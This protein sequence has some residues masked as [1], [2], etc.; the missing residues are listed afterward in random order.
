MASHMVDIPSMGLRI[1]NT[2]TQKKEDF[3]PVT[4][5][6]AS[7]YV[8]GVTVYDHCHI[9]HARSAIVFDTISRYLG[10][11]GYKLT[12]VKNFTDI[13]DKII[14]KARAEGISWKEVSEKYIA[15]FYEDMNALNILRPT[16]EPRATDH[17]DEMIG[18]VEALL[19]K[20]HA[21]KSEGD[22]YFSVESYK[23]YG[24]LSKR[25]LEE[26][27]A[28]ARVDINE[29]KQNPLDFAL[30]KASKPD[31]PSWETPFG[32][33][34]PGWHIEC[35]A[36][37]SKYLG[38]P[39]DIH[40]GGKDLV[41]PHH[42]NERA[43][44]EAATGVTF[45]NYW[46]HNGFVNVERE[47]MSKSIG[48]ILLIKDFLKQ[49]HPEV[50]RIFFLG[51]HY[52]NPVDYSERSIED[53]DS[54]LHRLYYTRERVSGI[55]ASQKT[56]HHQAHPDAQL[57]ETKFYEAMDDDFNTALALSYIFELSKILN[58]IADDRDES[59]LPYLGSTYQLLMNLTE[60]LGI[61]RDGADSFTEQDRVH[62]LVR[63][64]LEPADVEKAI[65]ERAE[66]RK[67]KDFK[68]AD[69]IR[70]MLSGKGILLLDTAKGT[71][72]RVKNTL[73][74]KGES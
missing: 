28:G 57:L 39:F 32:P 25:P 66:A 59:A 47:K 22:V 68:R 30:W 52:R 34:R 40:G 42:E 60:T 62:H 72:W 41:F 48:N 15:S 10:T 49:Y 26:M 27:E 45:V 14:N 70:D 46:V 55:L 8:C 71:E 54:A 64:G 67:G 29:K 24:Q 3:V 5:G 51:T 13:D 58:R 6:A 19:S 61:L 23:K 63:V 12:S 18:L 7:M 4:E 33:G 65:A 73:I 20:G 50:L 56:D 31:E 74:M 36:M 11:K 43:Q 69:E 37:S 1:Y 9:G 53:M 17:I 21:Y 44:S 16:Y 2:F 38:N 35:S